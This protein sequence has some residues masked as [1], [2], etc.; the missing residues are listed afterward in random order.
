MGIQLC[1]RPGRDLPPSLNLPAL[2][3][4]QGSYYNSYGSN[5]KLRPSVCFRLD[6]LHIY[7]PNVAH[8]HL[9]PA[10]YRRVYSSWI[11]SCSSIGHSIILQ[12]SRSSPYS[13]ARP[14]GLDPA[15]TVC[16]RRLSLW[17]YRQ[18]LVEAPRL[19]LHY[20]R[21]FY[22]CKATR[23]QNNI[24]SESGEVFSA[25]DIRAVV[26]CSKRLSCKRRTPSGYLHFSAGRTSQMEIT[27]GFM[28]L[29]ALLQAS[30]SA[31]R[32]YPA[33]HSIW[34]SYKLWTFYRL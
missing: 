13:S 32:H 18:L 26:S 29:S 27:H 16:S 3:H 17:L 21:N 34:T 33:G 23:L 22:S 7:F 20:A 9:V 15:L 12:D 31:P 2:R 14:P 24:E 28:H 8:I 30:H 5:V 6:F 1:T 11:L 4:L 10:S 25:N 19:A